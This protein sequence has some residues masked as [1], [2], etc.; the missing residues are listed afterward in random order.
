MIYLILAIIASALFSIMMRVGEQHCENNI[1]MLAVNY[2]VCC[3]FSLI[4]S[5]IDS[6]MQVGPGKGMAI[7]LGWI[8]GFFYIAGLVV[9]QKSLREN[10]LVLSS[11]FM[12]LGIMVPLVLSIFFFKEVPTIFQIIGFVIAI[13]AMVIINL[14]P[15]TVKSEDRISGKKMILFLVLLG[16]G[17]ADGMSKIYQ[18]IGADKY[19]DLFLLSTF[20]IAFLLSLLY[21]KINRQKFTKVEWMYGIMLGVPNYFSARFLLKALGEVPAVVVYPTFSMG[22]IA[23]VTLTGMFIFREKISKLQRFAIALISVAVALLN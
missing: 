12:K 7:A 3:F 4:Y 1:C 22:T 6:L 13:I 21:G 2:T 16:G 11:I 5:G 10:G 20:I 14:K 8:N 19:E 15:D 9:F 18:E 23:V 17:T